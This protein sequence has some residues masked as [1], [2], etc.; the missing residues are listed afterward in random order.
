[1]IYIKSHFKSIFDTIEDKASIQ[2][3]FEWKP[4]C[5]SL[6]DQQ[7]IMELNLYTKIDGQYRQ[8]TYRLIP[9][10]IQSLAVFP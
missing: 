8:S 1:M 6:T 4:I 5:C 10:Y 2:N 7:C 9:H 3:I